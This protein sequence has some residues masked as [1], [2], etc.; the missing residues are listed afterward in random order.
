M[1][2]ATGTIT[3]VQEQR[4]KVAGNDGTTRH[5]ILSHHASLDGSDLLRLQQGGRPVE[6]DYDDVDELV[7]HVAYQVKEIR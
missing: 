1:R 7:G 3:L 2:S 4:F 5:F 6:V